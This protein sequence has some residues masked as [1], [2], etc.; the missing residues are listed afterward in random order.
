MRVTMNYGRQGLAL[1]FPDSWDIELIEKREMPVQKD[2]ELSIE[3]ALR[4]GVGSAGLAH[5]AAGKKTACILICDI[6]RPVPNGLILPPVV[7]TLLKSGMAPQNI[8]I[9][10]ATGLHRPNLDGEMREVVGSDWVLETVEVANHYARQDA[11]HVPVGTTARGTEALLDRRFA[12]ADLRLVVG[13]VEPHLMAG[14]SGGRKVITPGVCHERTI[15]RLHSAEYMEHP[16]ATNCVLVD[17]PLHEEQLEIVR[18]L[19]G[20]LSVNTVIDPDRRLSFVN[21]G[22]IVESHLEAVQFIRSYAEVIVPRPYPAVVTSAAGY[23]L[24]KTYYQTIKGMV[25]AR[26]ILASGGDLFIVSEIS[27][28][29]GSTEYAAAQRLLV[30]LGIDGFLNEL[31]GRRH[32]RVDEWQTEMQLKPMRQG[33]IH[34]YTR[35]LDESERE[36]TGV[37][38][39]EDLDAFV[40]A[41]HT[42]VADHRR[43]AVIPEGPYVMPFVSR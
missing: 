38:V 17:N 3:K 19:G 21:F 30:D 34:L 6:T 9:L 36:L 10:I 22:D 35:G 13:L 32:A 37:H 39:L 31:Q 15:R 12:E 43:L 33:R 25:A 14:Y 41:V 1:E 42:S 8:R 20:A 5:E 7:R 18:L 27:E 23:P 28:G 11:D 4:D 16:C 26:E 24:D 29:F 40:E 2:P